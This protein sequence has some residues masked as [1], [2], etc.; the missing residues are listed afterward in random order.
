MAGSVERRGAWLWS[1]HFALAAGRRKSLPPST[2]T[3]PDP[4]FL[5]FSSKL[6]RAIPKLSIEH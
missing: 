2:K 4:F 6:Q 1:R 3:T 5:P